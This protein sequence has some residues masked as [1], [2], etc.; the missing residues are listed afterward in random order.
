MKRY[1]TLMTGLFVLTVPV[2]TDA[3]SVNTG[4]A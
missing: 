3:A 2:L 4:H 1:V